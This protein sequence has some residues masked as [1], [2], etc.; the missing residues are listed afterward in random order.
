MT[1]R[2]FRYTKRIKMTA[3]AIL[4]EEANGS[5]HWLPKAHAEHGQY[6]NPDGADFYFVDLPEW[7][8][9]QK[10]MSDEITG[11]TLDPYGVT[12]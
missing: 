6:A 12:R 1:E 11:M 4:A 5:Q 8:A 2:R 9:A 7:L 10:N 3:K